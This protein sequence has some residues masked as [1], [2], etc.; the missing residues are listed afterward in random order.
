MGDPI[1]GGPFGGDPFVGRSRCG[2]PFG[3]RSLSLWEGASALIPSLSCLSHSIESLTTSP[4]STRTQS[5][6]ILPQTL[7]QEETRTRLRISPHLP[8]PA[9]SELLNSCRA[10]GATKAL[11]VFFLFELLLGM[12][13]LHHVRV[14]QPQHVLLYG[15]QGDLGTSWPPL[16]STPQQCLK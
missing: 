7:P 4:D 3:G 9:L 11:S 16:K 14:I 1:V 13:V 10:A 15:T 2:D 8:L 6:F 5:P 12:R